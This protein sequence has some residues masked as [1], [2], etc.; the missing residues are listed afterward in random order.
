MLLNGG[1]KLHAAPRM[2][3]KSES[4]HPAALP[5][6]DLLADCDVRRTRRSG[7]GGQ[8]RN[9]VETA[10]V[11]EHRPTGLFAEASER[12]SQ[13]ENRQQAIHRLRLNLALRVRRPIAAPFAPSP[14]WRSRCRGDRVYVNETHEDFPALL[15]EALDVV[16][17]RGIDLKAAAQELGCTR[18]Q[19]TKLLYQEPQ[20]MAIVNA[21]RQRAGLH[22]LK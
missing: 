19:L 12:R 15:A 2:A 10:V 11:I 17:A 7:P 14:L 3:L 9:K 20:A 16:I 5:V 6:D 4:V 22:K 18:S 21:A 8:H 1:P 13:E